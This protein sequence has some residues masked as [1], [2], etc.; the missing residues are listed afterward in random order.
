MGDD[1][2][3][4]PFFLYPQGQESIPGFGQRDAFPCQFC[5]R[6]AALYF[7]KLFSVPQLILGVLIGGVLFGL[8][9]GLCV[10]SYKFFDKYIK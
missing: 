8:P 3:R 7:V 5:L 10:V 9:I 6:I 1:K 2:F 4:G